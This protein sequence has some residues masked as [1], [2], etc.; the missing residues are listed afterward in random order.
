MRFKF[1][2]AMAT[3]LPMA[4]DRTDNTTSIWLQSAC[5]APSASGSKRIA[6]ANA[7]SFE[8]VP[9]NTVTQVGE[10]SYTSGIHMW[11]GTAPNL[12]PT[13][14]MRNAM[15]NTRPTL[16]EKPLCTAV[17]IAASSRL[18]VTPYRIDMPYSKVP[19]AIEPSTKY[20]MADSAAMPESRSN[21]TM[22]YRHSDINS[23]PKYSVIRL[24]AEMRTMAPN[25]ANRPRTKYSP[26]RMARR[27]R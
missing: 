7:A 19:E 21:A 11:N 8:A 5:D 10:P 1:V 6:R 22:A 4:I 12:K 26:L 3:M 25:V 9:M 27:R 14:T 2:C 15:P 24:P 18:P 20:L 17:A 23:K 16:S 13:P